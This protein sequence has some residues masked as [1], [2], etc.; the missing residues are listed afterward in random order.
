[1]PPLDPYPARPRLQLGYFGAPGTPDLH[2]SVDG[3]TP[4]GPNLSHWPG[5]RPINP[6]RCAAVH[7]FNPK[8]PKHH[9]QAA[10]RNG[11]Q[12]GKRTIGTF[13]PTRKAKA[14]HHRAEI[15]RNNNRQRQSGKPR[16]PD[17]RTDGR[18]RA[19]IV[20]RCFRLCHS[21]RA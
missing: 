8:R 19:R 9:R 4:K 6:G 18:Y 14:I 5:K 1:M 20:R 7:F 13:G 15:A 2:L 17:R 10:S 12:S 11:H 16:Q 21:N 3:M